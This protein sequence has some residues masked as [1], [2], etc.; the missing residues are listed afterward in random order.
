MHLSVRYLKSRFSSVAALLAIT[1]GVAVILILLAIMGGYISQLRSTIRG[2]ESDVTLVAPQRYGI[3]RIHRLERLVQ[4]VEN[5]SATAPFVDSLAMYR[6]GSFSPCQLHGIHPVKQTRASRFGA[7]AIRPGELSSA[8]SSLQKAG[9]DR[10]ATREKTR[11]DLEALLRD[12][13]REPLTADEV[14]TLFSRDY[15]QEILTRENPAMLEALQ[16]EIP[17]VALVGAQLLIDG[18]VFVG[19]LLTL[20]TVNPDQPEP[21][22]RPFL[23]AGAFKTGDFEADSRDIY[24]HVDALKSMLKLFDPTA[25]SYK[26]EGL[27]IALK[28]A[29]R[30]EESKKE[31]ENTLRASPHYDDL[32][33]FGWED[34]RKNLLRAVKIE[35]FIVFFLLVVVQSFAGFMVLLMLTLIVIDKTRDMGVLLALGATP[36][37]LTWVFLTN[38]LLL[39][40]T[41]TALGLGVGYAFCVNINPLH[42]WI[43]TV[44]G[45]RLFDPRIYNMDRIPITISIQDVL[46]SV[47]TPLT[48]GF[49]ASLAPA[50]WASRRDPIKAIHYE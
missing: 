11:Q 31:I 17:P 6:S 22:S 3:T 30:L 44:T 5:V 18:D 49:L 41:G 21:I 37:G 20:V 38:G 9:G 28:D 4:T 10:Q 8:L 15:A 43:F 25:N 2:Q 45:V 40:V 16:G 24:V 23:V 39:T 42:D 29:T 13:T 12:P 7:Y 36:N 14:R 27:R 46:L 1:F 26:Y 35:K 34:L 50:I 32:T 33:V 47:A 48:F 19:Q